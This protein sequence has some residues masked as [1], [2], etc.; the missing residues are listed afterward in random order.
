MWKLH[1]IPNLTA[2]ALLALSTASDPC[3]AQ[4]EPVGARA[5]NESENAGVEGVLEEI[6]VTA[7]FR[8]ESIQ[9]IG[10][11]VSALGGDDLINHGVTN[12]DD[13]ARSTVGLNNIRLRQN[14]NEV[15]IR[16]VSNLGTSFF[17]SSSVFTT[18]VDDI[19]VVSTFGQRDFGMLDLDRIELVRGPQP[20]LF[21]EGAVGGVIR[22]FTRDPDLSGPT[23]TAFTSGQ[24]ET[25]NG[26]GL[27]YLADGAASLIFT[28]EKSGLRVSGYYRKDEGF[29]DNRLS[30]EE[31]TN[32][33][34]SFGARAVLLL[35]P[36]DRLSARLSAFVARDEHAFDSSIEPGT[37][38]EDLVFGIPG[39]PD[40]VYP[41][42]V[43]SGDDDFDLYSAR[44]SYDFGLFEVTSITGLYN[45]DRQIETLDIGTTVGLQPF[46]P[47]INTTSF[48]SNTF[49]EDMFSEELRVVSNFNGPLNFIA[50]AFYRDRD[51]ALDRR[52]VIP[53]LPAVSTPPSDVGQQN[54]TNNESS[55]ISGFAELTW[56]VTDRLRLI[57][58]VRYVDDTYTSNFEETIVNLN[59]ANAPW[60]PS[61]P[62]D[63]LF[64]NDVLS[65]IG[66][67]PP[68]EFKLTEFLPR[69]AVEFD[70][71]DDILIYA[72]G[73]RGIRNGG[74][75]SALAAVASSGD[76]ADADFFDTFVENLLFD[77]DSVVGVDIG[78][79]AVWLDG[80][81][82]TNIGLFRTKY[83]DTQIMVLAPVSNTVNGPDQVIEGV[84]LETVHR[85]SD[86]F[87]TSFNATLLDSE[88][89]DDFSIT[90]IG[91][92]IRKGNDAINAPGLSY[93]FG[94]DYSKPM[95]GRWNLVSSGDFQYI[96]ER[97]S[98]ASNFPSG[99]LDPIGILNFRFGIESERLSL[100]AFVRNALNDVEAIS[101]AV[102][103]ETRD[104]NGNAIDGPV[105]AQYVNQPRSVGVGFTVRY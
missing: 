84:E 21:G 1:R 83:E 12:I 9:D 26:G 38:P 43:A 69:A 61:N 73:A 13:L 42:F 32:D 51:F 96:G 36:N 35:Q 86:N 105:T 56:S 58:G 65:A 97:F 50:G 10:A 30:G 62:I 33:F 100:T 15:S 24:I 80:A 17:S 104:A 46:L 79:K 66:V 3:F 93:S 92:D 40:G 23:Y 52:L 89:Q 82:T 7:R 31:D 101:S 72:N 14:D 64:I 60:T 4:E 16:G 29:I 75:G 6:I 8:E 78:V 19:S 63:F 87:S 81:I 91:N 41:D 67:P 99:E 11:G 25:M 28:P 59:P 34:S 103:G 77:E 98:D 68:F 70:V 90:G 45:R 2:A 47:T 57:G 55:Q 22:Y 39:L 44:I 20:T 71:N 49:A 102:S 54:V 37:D 27:A 94:Y 74:V 5:G 18:Y 53:D 76:P 85:W 88:F 48:G 95:G